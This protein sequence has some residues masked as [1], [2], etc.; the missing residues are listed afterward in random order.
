MQ[1]LFYQKTDIFT[2]IIQFF[3]ILIEQQLGT[4]DISDKSHVLYRYFI[5]KLQEI[6]LLIFFV[7]FFHCL[8]IS[9]INRILKEIQDIYT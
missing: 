1:N 4:L 3:T 2:Y 8:Q 9:M 6:S 7:N 5:I